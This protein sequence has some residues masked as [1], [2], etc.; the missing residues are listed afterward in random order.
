MTATRLLRGG[1]S[2]RVLESLGIDPKRYWLLLDLFRQ[3]A[4]RREILTQLGGNGMALKAAAWMYFVMSGLIGVLLAMAA[5]PVASYFAGFLTI[6]AILLLG[7]LMSETSNSIV[8]PEEGLVL[9]HQPINGATYT[10]AKLTHLLRILV[11]LVPALN[12][13]PALAG[14]TLRD[15]AWTYPLLHMLAAFAVGLLAALLC[16]AL[17]GWLVRFVPAPR[18]KA[19]GQI[20][21]AL[22]WTAIVLVQFAGIRLSQLRMQA[23]LPADPSVR[24]FLAVASAFIAAAIVVLGLRSLS[25]DYLIRVS[26]IVHGSSAAKAKPRRSRLAGLVAR[27]FGGQAARAGFEY[28]SRMMRRDWQFRRQMI[29]TIP[30]LVA[31]IVLVVSG[32]GTS[33]FSGGFTM[34]HLLPHVFGLVFFWICTLLAFGNDYKGGWVFLLAPAGAFD[35]FARGV[36]ALLW[37]G[38]VVIPHLVVLVVLAVYWAAWEAAL[39][40]AYSAAVASAYLGLE[41]RLI[42]GVPFGKQP[43]ASRSAFMMPLLIAGSLAMALVVAVQYWFVFRSPARAAAVTALAGVAALVVTRGSLDAFAVSMRYELGLLAVESASLYKEVE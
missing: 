40:V 41:L 20:A 36:H 3:L 14:L 31:P 39:F 2:S 9:A 26:S 28:V 16:C 10:A 29:P 19:A 32:L 37:I 4:E 11:Y 8:N 33:P 7:I 43:E 12:A 34:M 5:P 22:P 30:A 13:V 35:G 17:F 23:L 38:I 21:E 6:T 1:A 15:A 42:H 27:W 18:L 25:G 24:A